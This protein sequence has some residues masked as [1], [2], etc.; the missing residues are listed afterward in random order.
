LKV[1]VLELEIM[2]YACG[3]F[4]AWKVRIELQRRAEIENKQIAGFL[5]SSK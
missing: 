3:L 5:D 2:V 1:G 4:T